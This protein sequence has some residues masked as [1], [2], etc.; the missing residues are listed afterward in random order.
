M[1]KPN[2]PPGEGGANRPVTRNDDGCPQLLLSSSSQSAMLVTDEMTVCD[3]MPSS[4][5]AVLLN[6]VSVNPA[7]PS[8]NI[9]T[10]VPLQNLVTSTRQV[11]HKG[12]NDVFM[13]SDHL[14][15]L[16][17][18]IRKNPV[19]FSSPFQMLRSTTNGERKTQ[20]IF[21]E[22]YN[23]TTMFGSVRPFRL[24]PTYHGMARRVHD[25]ASC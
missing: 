8:G 6:L 15:T 24:S 14:P 3:T 9:C 22:T 17:P 5:H 10:A 4:A 20:Q 7:L 25:I 13:V 23:T 2:F 12:M 11:I 21:F 19:F 18:T 1:L 16:P